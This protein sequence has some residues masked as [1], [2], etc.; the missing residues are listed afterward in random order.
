MSDRGEA[1]AS[2]PYH[3]L[4]AAHLWREAVAALPPDAV[5]PQEPSALRL[6]AQTRIASAGSCFAQRL[7]AALVAHG[8]NYFVA[9]PGPPW[10]SARQRRDFN[11]GTYSARYGN[12][13]TA[14][15]LVQLL[16][17][18]LGTFRPAES[19]WP[20]PGG[21]WFD[22][23]RPRIQPDGFAS[24]EELLADREHHL[25]A[26]KTLFETAEVFVFT[27]GLTEAWRSRQDGTVFP[28]CPGCG[29]GRF[30]PQNY[31]FQN[32]RVGEVIEHLNRFLDR[33]AGVN[34]AAQVILTVSPVPLAATFSGKH[35]L[36]ATTYSKSVLRVAAEEVAAAR[37][38]VH[39][40]ASYEIATATGDSRAYFAA[41]RREVSE[42]CVA[43]VTRAFFET[44]AG[45]LPAPRTPAEAAPEAG[46]PGEVIC[47]EVAMLEALGDQRRDWANS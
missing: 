19:P 28:V 5:T 10:L 45:G 36:Q 38:N 8:F 25:R 2:C 37:P 24:R 40:F 22:P 42:A 12:V 15:Q 47:D 27:L 9:E 32:F 16:E 13:Y 43:H 35:V 30:D 1:Y 18:A 46:P 20:G 3:D 17:Q 6:T 11:Y 23:L 31:H 29:A 39:Y 4:S 7:S 26:V 33:L 34:A 44:F 41:D 14:L 21:R